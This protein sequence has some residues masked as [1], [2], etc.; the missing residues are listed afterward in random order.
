MI[1][2]TIVC[3]KAEFDAIYARFKGTKDNLTIRYLLVEGWRSKYHAQWLN[4]LR[5]T[6]FQDIVTVS[7][8]L[9]YA[10]FE[11]FYTELRPIDTDYSSQITLYNSVIT[12]LQ[13]NPNMAPHVSNLLKIVDDLTLNLKNQAFNA[14]SNYTLTQIRA[15]NRY[16][17]IRAGK[18]HL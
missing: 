15:S 7:K 2:N 12:A 9:P 11:F 14:D 5:A 13:A 1:C 3:T 4:D 17:Y 8:T 10:F 6:Y 16:S 18:H